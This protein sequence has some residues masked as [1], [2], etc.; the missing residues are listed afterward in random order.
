MLMC[1]RVVKSFLKEEM[2]LFSE[3]IKPKDQKKLNCY[4]S[5]D[6]RME[7]DHILQFLF[8]F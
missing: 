8:T 5:M 6:A 3:Y 4:I 2:Q 1:Y 7:G